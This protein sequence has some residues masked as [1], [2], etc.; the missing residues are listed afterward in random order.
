VCKIC[1]KVICGDSVDDIELL[2]CDYIAISPPKQMKLVSTP[3]M[4]LS[5]SYDS[6]I[7]V[8]SDNQSTD[9]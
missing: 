5:K 4:C 1:M 3:I 2:D 7:S 6:E 8:G 9:N